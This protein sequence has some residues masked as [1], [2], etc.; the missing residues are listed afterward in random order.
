[1]SDKYAEAIHYLQPIADSASDK[2]SYGAML[3]LAIQA[4]HAQAER[5]NPQPLTLDELKSM[6]DKPVYCVD[7]KG[8]GM[9]AFVQL[10]DE[11]CTDCHYGDWEFY[12]YGWDNDDGWL[13]YKNKQKEDEL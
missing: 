11:V 8:A 3:N 1:M 2:M 12:C 9:W 13:A 5:E 10:E 4:L 7:S 6:V